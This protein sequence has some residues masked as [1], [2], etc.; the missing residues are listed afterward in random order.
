MDNNKLRKISKKELLEILLSQ[1]KRIDELEQELNKTK[2]K[3]ESKKITIEKSGS[4]AEAA[5]KLNNI[6]ENAEETAKQ[7]LLNI[8]EKCKKI[9]NETKKTLQI[10][11]ENM[12]KET[13]EICKKL[14]TETEKYC[15]EKK[16]EADNYLKNIKEKNNKTQKKKETVKQKNNKDKIKKQEDILDTKKE[17]LVVAKKEIEQS[18]K[19]SSSKQLVNKVVIEKSKKPIEG[20][21]IKSIKRKS[22]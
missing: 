21:P 15:Q 3:L 17:Q 12:L 9:E 5:L 8:K 20:R 10:E 14:K 13:E 6:F 11:K 19:E 18:K 22:K 2:S 1:T 7:Y 4:I 16:K